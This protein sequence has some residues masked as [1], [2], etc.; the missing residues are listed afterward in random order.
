MPKPSDNFFIAGNPVTGDNFFGRK[1]VLESI[2]HSRNPL[3]FIGLRRIG[4]SSLLRQ[5]YIKLD[6]K[7]NLVVL[8]DGAGLSSS[9]TDEFIRY[10][11]ERL[12]FSI[13]HK[14]KAIQEK[15]QK[16]K[17]NL[18]SLEQQEK[19][20]FSAFTKI[21]GN[22]NNDGFKIYLLIDEIDSILRYSDDEAVRTA[23]LVRS[24]SQESEMF[25]T[26]CT[27]FVEPT[28][29]QISSPGSSWYNIFSIDYLG[30]FTE[31]E[32]IEMLT[33]LSQKSGNILTEGECHFLMDIFG[34]FPFFLQSAGLYLM[35][36][37]DFRSSNQST[38][39]QAF[40]KVIP[41]A[42]Y[43]LNNFH[44]NYLL[45]HLDA[46]ALLLLKK[47]SDGKKPSS[48]KDEMLFWK[49]S[50]LG[51]IVETKEKPSLSSLIL[52]EAINS[53]QEKE[54]L[55]WDKVRDFTLRTIETVTME[56]MKVAINKYL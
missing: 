32:A 36:D 29:V 21:L 34:N 23:A 50:K 46:E 10:F 30:L 52:R 35:N 31:N 5:A 41:Q 22:I 48:A 37:N 53:I 17:E 40:T 25:Q 16:A 28:A 44:I 56:A 3:I 42:I 54:L 12:F 51:L 33:T 2:L 1:Q 11:S 43:S 24:L 55:N 19:V 4:K 15:L 9:N 26:V 47:I 38:R 20:R 6:T 45:N 18:D 14:P 13:E 39:K 8:L 27:T 49:L 7:N